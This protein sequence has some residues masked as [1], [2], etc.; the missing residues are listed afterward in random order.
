M[1]IVLC[2]GCIGPNY[3]FNLHLSKTQKG[4]T[5]LV[6]AAEIGRAE[7]VRLLVQ[8]GAKGVKVQVRANCAIDV[9]SF[10]RSTPTYLLLYASQLFS[11]LQ[12]HACARIYMH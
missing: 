3:A 12:V 5:A 8:G 11:I 2:R 1:T 7:C 4:K 9:H 10:M 6:C